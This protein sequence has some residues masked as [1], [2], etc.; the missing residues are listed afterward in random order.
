MDKD[1]YIKQLEDKI[2]ELE[3]R[4]EELEQLSWMN[5]KNSSKP[6]SSDTPG[7]SV[8]LPKRRRKKRGAKKALVMLNEVFSVPMTLGG[9]SN[10]EAQLAVARS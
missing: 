6:L 7:M 10:C 9:L 5:S 1:A 8:V 3:K 2:I 4:I